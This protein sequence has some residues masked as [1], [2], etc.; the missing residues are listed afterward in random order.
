MAGLD[1]S[2][3]LVVCEALLQKYEATP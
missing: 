2:A 1:F 3:A